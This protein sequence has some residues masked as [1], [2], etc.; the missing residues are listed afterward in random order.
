LKAEVEIRYA[1]D[2]KMIYKGPPCHVCWI[3]RLARFLPF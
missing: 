1:D 2:G 3:Q